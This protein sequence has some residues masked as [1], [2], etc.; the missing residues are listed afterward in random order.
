MSKATI[1]LFYAFGSRVNL[2]FWTLKYTDTMNKQTTY[3]IIVTSILT[4]I[5][6]LVI[7]PLSITL[8]FWLNDYLARPIISIEHLEVIPTYKKIKTPVD[9]LSKVANSMYFQKATM[10]NR[11]GRYGQIIHYLNLPQLNEEEARQLVKITEEFSTRLDGEILDIKADLSTI[12]TKIDEEKLFLLNQKYG[13]NISSLNIDYKNQILQNIKEYLALSKLFNIYL[14]NILSEIANH[15]SKEIEKLY[16]KLT[17]L[18]K[19]NT[20]GLI[21]N[22][23][24]IK[25]P[26]TDISL[27]IYA[28]KP[29]SI[30]NSMAISVKMAGKD[31]SAPSVNSVGKIPIHSMIE[32]WYLIDPKQFTPDVKVK[33]RKHLTSSDRFKVF[34]SFKDHEGSIIKNI[35]TIKTGTPLQ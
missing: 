20:D 6:A 11:L 33:L 32:N 18:N 25:I 23:G 15:S 14:K 29:P 5:G 26:N 34:T 19:G 13:L 8:G 30:E 3:I 22:F 24:T 7:S 4:S 35:F 28:S 16:F 12:K 21:K 31:Y 1:W 17:F 9:G 27:S 10:Q 2:K